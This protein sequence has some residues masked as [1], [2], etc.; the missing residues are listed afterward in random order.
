MEYLVKK[1][2]LR[3]SKITANT[4]KGKTE[5]WV[6]SITVPVECMRAKGWKLGQE[7]I[8]YLTDEGIVYKEVEE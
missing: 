6:F 8:P 4:K 3:K 5:Y 2:K 1:V 7:F